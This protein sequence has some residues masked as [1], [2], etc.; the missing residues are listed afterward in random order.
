M[1]SPD[2]ANVRAARPAKKK[3]P[4]T[5]AQRR[6]RHK[7]LWREIC[8]RA[9]EALAKRLL[10]ITRK[11]SRRSQK[12]TSPNSPNVEVGEP[13]IEKCL[14]VFYEH[15]RAI[16]LGLEGEAH[17]MMVAVLRQAFLLWRLQQEDRARHSCEHLQAAL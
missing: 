6:R 2:S 8:R 1:S 9:D 11:P 13:I 10:P 17:E 4:E 14:E 7:A 5:D 3:K 15:A 12:S 16:E